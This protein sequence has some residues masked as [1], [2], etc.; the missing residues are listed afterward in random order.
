[1][2]ENRLA[3]PLDGKSGDEDSSSAVDQPDLN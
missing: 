3:A 2:L 1:M